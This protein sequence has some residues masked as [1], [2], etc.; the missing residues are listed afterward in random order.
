[1]LNPRPVFIEVGDQSFNAWYIAHVKFYSERVEVTLA[2]G[3]KCELFSDDA[4]TFTRQYQNF[5][6][7]G[8][9]RR[10]KGLREG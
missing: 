2:S 4:Q 3:K 6:D 5:Q 8:D 7:S 9:P 10:H 1:M